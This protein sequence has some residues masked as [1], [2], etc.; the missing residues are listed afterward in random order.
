MTIISMLFGIF[1]GAIVLTGCIRLIAPRFGLIA[2]PVTRSAHVAET[3]S[4][5]GA[6]I[7]ALYL[8]LSYVFF[9]SGMIPGN[10]YLAI[11]GAL[12]I[13]FMGLV[14]DVSSLSLH[15][16]LPVQ[17]FAAAWA[18]YWLGGVPGIDFSLFK[19]TTPWLLSIMGVFALVWLVNLYNFMDGIDAIAGTQLIFVNVLSL[20]LVINNE[21]QV[22]A[23]LSAVLAA[24]T[25]GFLVWNWPPAKIFMGDTGSCF[26]GYSLGVLALLSMHHGMMSIWTWFILLGVFVVD[27]G[28]TLCSR[29]LQGMRWQEGHAS[30]A[31]Q[32]ATRDFKSHKKVTLTVLAINVFWL[33]PWAWLSVKYP[34]IGIYLCVMALSPLVVLA[35]KFRAGV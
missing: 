32:N 31:Y 14:D 3:P 5:G 6:A 7:A 35:N 20:M 18:V 23:L 4:G 22:V 30:H 16:R 11:S 1:I 17:F 25:A 29:V 27:T 13:A 21:N 12:L 33:A 2:V 15:Y 8:L 28:V 26:I 9:K 10:E 19:I 34:E 24:A